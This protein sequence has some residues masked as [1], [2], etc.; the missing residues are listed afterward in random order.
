MMQAG[1]SPA[2]FTFLLREGTSKSHFKMHRYVGNAA[3]FLALL[4]CFGRGSILLTQQSQVPGSRPVLSPE[5][6]VSLAEQGRC[7]ESISDLKHAMATTV[8]AEVR[9]QAGVLGVRCSLGM[10]DRDA[11]NEF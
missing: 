4:G 3:V 11:A 7:G 2:S 10:D 8:P 5:K 1:T 9:K 6:A